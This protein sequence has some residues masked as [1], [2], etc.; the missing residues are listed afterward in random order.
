MSILNGTGHTDE[1]RSEANMETVNQKR[2]KL[3]RNAEYW[4]RLR[5]E[6][7]RWRPLCR[8]TG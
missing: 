7:S 8:N 4:D 6:T 5:Y 2:L 1:N 3:R